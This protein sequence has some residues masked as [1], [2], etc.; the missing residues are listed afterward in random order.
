MFEGPLVE[1]WAKWMNVDLNAFKEKSKFASS[2]NS[3]KEFKHNKDES[4]GW[5]V[6]KQPTVYEKAKGGAKGV[7]AF[8]TRAY[9]FA[10]L[11]LNFD[12]DN[13]VPSEKK[14][15]EPFKEGHHLNKG[16]MKVKQLLEL[17][18]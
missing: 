13:G 12:K 17:C 8:T 3:I 7:K 14:G 4:K 16:G 10:C 2:W 1:R 5:K 9:S 11:G 15:M 18:T 6:N